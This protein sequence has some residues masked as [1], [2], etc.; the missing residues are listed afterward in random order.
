MFLTSS[1]ATAGM[2]VVPLSA[3]AGDLVHAGHGASR[4]A[5]ATAGLGL[6]C[7]LNL[8]QVLHPQAV[9][10]IAMP[11]V[12][13]NFPARAAAPASPSLIRQAVQGNFGG[14]VNESAVRPSIFNGLECAAPQWRQRRQCQQRR[15]QRLSPHQQQ[16]NVVRPGAVESVG[17]RRRRAAQ[18]LMS[19]PLRKPATANR[20]PS[21]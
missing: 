21:R 10:P 16:L 18:P 11:P 3:E 2:A 8:P 14:Q 9:G 15:G 5:T 7:D 17:P 20:R 6:D 12:S 1:L 13:N 19:L 4:S